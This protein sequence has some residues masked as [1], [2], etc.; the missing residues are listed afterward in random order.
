MKAYEELTE[1]GQ[2]RRI[3]PIALSLLKKHNRHYESLKLINHGENT[4]FRAKYKAHNY[5][6]RIHRPGY[7]T[8]ESIR[9]EMELLEHYRSFGLNVPKPIWLENE[10]VFSL[11][12]P[13]VEARFA[14]LFDW[15]P[16]RFSDIL[17][18]KSAHKIGVFMGQMH[19]ASEK[20]RPSKTF[21]RPRLDNTGVYTVMGGDLSFFSE[22]DQDLITTFQKHADETLQKIGQS[23]T[24]FGMVHCDFHSGNRLSHNGEVVAID[25]DDSGWSWFIYDIAVCLSSHDREEHYATFVKLFFEGYRSVR[26]ISQLEEQ[27]LELLMQVRNVQMLLWVAG[28]T[29]NPSFVKS[30]PGYTKHVRKMLTEFLSQRKKGILK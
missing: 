4:T 7:Q 29:D 25:F 30:L 1:R 23:K 17:T 20:F 9:S 27:S 3:R 8:L 12:A 19:L 10:A 11:E 5:L 15:L 13:N 21:F 6:C 16:G 24:V 2:V 28:R 26:S 22:S 14:V 18:K